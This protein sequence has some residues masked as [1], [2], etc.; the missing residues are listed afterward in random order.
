MEGGVRFGRH[1]AGYWS[2][3]RTSEFDE[4]CQ[5]AAGWKIEHQLL[6]GG[7]PLSSLHGIVTPAMQIGEVEHHSGYSSQGATRSGGTSFILSA[8]A[9]RPIV[10]CGRPLG[11]LNVLTSTSDTEFELVARLGS[12]HFVVWLPTAMLEHA[13]IDLL[14]HPLMA[15]ARRRTLRYSGESARDYCVGMVRAF[16]ARV[17]EQP[18]LLDD[19]RAADEMRERLST[20]L[21]LETMQESWESDAPH[22]RHAARRA[23]EYMLQRLD[24]PPAVRDLCRVSGANYATLER[25][26]QEVYGL[27][28]K[29]FL[30]SCRL[31]R[32]HRELRQPDAATTVTDAAVKWGFYELGRFSAEYRKRFGVSP[33]ETLR[34]APGGT[35]AR[36]GKIAS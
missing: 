3:I 20:A 19:G 16:I 27:S 23:R 29:A 18:G 32:V 8:S 33:S 26:F 13:A 4:F 1:A 24:N 12:R 28:P 35:A 6:G 9:D 2:S 36:Q 14:G 21:L 30:K 17:K 15:E 10:Y 11:P 25:G 5:H 22:R 7:R 31:T 34:S